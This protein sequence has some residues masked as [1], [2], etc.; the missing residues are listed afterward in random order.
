MMSGPMLLRLKRKCL[1]VR[2]YMPMVITLM[3]RKVLQFF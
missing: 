3:H 1:V 2:I